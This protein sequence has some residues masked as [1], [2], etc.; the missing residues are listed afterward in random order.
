MPYKPE[1]LTNYTPILKTVPTL[2]GTVLS[3][4]DNKVCVEF[5]SELIPYILT[6]LELYR[7]E[8]KFSGTVADKKRS[9][10]VFQDLMR[11]F[12]TAS[13]CEGNS[14]I[15][16]IRVNNCV[17]EYLID[18]VWTPVTS[19][20]PSCFTGPQGPEGPQGIQGPAGPEGP[21]GPQGIQGPAGPEGPQGPQGPAGAE[22]DIA[23]VSVP[24]EITNVNDAIFGAC[25]A[26]VQYLYEECI[27]Y[28]GIA[29]AASSTIDAINNAIAAIPGFG[30]LY[31]LSGFDNAI[32]ALSEFGGLTRALIEADYDVQMQRALAC[33]L[34][35]LI[36]DNNDKF[37]K[38]VFAQALIPWLADNPLSSARTAI[39][40]YG[41][42]ATLGWFRVINGEYGINLNNPDA[43]W[44]VLCTDCAPQP[45][46][47][48]F[49]GFGIGNAI[50]P[51]TV[52]FTQTT[53]T[54]GTYNAALDLADGTPAPEGNG[55]WCAVDIPFTGT[56]ARIKMYTEATSQQFE[57]T[58]GWNQFIYADGNQLATSGRNGQLSGTDTLEWT[59]SVSVTNTISVQTGGWGTSGVLRITRI[60]V[61]Y[62]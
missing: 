16:E 31:D 61:D 43:D 42:W 34:Y 25:M 62:T 32:T 58:I 1:L 13:S 60:E 26:L 2:P 36:K 3:A 18:G 23:E 6:V 33:D 11:I 8:D 9:V 21:Q 38:A 28:A 47:I 51:A 56:I 35:C 57:S 48:Y 45:Q 59:G 5:N 30:Q 52:L 39:V 12:M 27:D 50:T 24:A 41:S 29:E 44:Q 53:G 46:T 19:F 22:G 37:S 17:L 4:Y 40:A 7:W 10:G 54:Y 49:D 55:L 15:T 20:E 14:V